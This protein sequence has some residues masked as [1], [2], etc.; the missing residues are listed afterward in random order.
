MAQFILIFYFYCKLSKYNFQ[1][2]SIQF[3]YLVFGYYFFVGDLHNAI[4]FPRSGTKKYFQLQL[5]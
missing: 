5:H 4:P 3:S 1:L 2:E